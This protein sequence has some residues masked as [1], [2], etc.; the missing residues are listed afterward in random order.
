MASHIY[1]TCMLST[2]HIRD[3]Y[4]TYKHLYDLIC[5]LYVSRMI[6]PYGE[7][8]MCH[9]GKQETKSY[10]TS[11]QGTSLASCCSTCSVQGRRHHAQSSVNPSTAVS[12]RYHQRAQASSS[13]SVIDT[14]PACY[15]QKRT[16]DW[17]NELSASHLQQ[18][19]TLFQL[20]YFLLMLI[21]SLLRRNSKLIY[22][23]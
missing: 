23:Q 7:L 20:S 1:E 17:L 6:F 19:G 22:L 9:D 15:P 4:L 5:I 14:E 18:S 12:G 13:A 11:P 8:C 3:I 10:K 21:T 2:L 16:P